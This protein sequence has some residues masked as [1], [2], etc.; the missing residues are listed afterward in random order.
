MNE[1]DRLARRDFLKASAATLGA[2]IPSGLFAAPV[3]K[4][5]RPLRL[6]ILGGTGFIGP[7]MAEYAIARGHQ[8]TLF[9]RGRREKFVGS[10]DRTEK[11]YGNRDPKLHA[12]SKVV[13]G[14]EIDDETSPK[15]LVELEGKKWDAVIDNSGYVPRIVKASAELLAPNV[16]QY[17][18]ISTL[19]VYADNS[20]PGLDESDTIAKIDDP[21]NEEIQ[22]HYGALKALCEQAAEKAMPKRVT[23]LRPGYI[24][25][26]KDL[27]DRF[28][29]W[30]I[31]TTRGGEVLVPGTPED[32][33]QFI[34]V[35]DLVE[36]AVHCVEHRTMGTFNVTGPEKKL[37]VGKLMEACQ[38]ASKANGDKGDAK[39]TYVPYDWLAM[40]GAPLG[41]LPILLPPTGD[42]AGFHQRSVAAAVK[43]GL[44]YR[45]P[46][47]TC[48]ALIKWWPEAV[49]LRE[50]VAKEVNEDRKAKNLPAA[51]QP[52]ADQLRAG[53]TPSAESKLLSLW[54]AKEKGN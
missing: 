15:G 9:N 53:L 39:F 33:V 13:D 31:R 48:S 46:E 29:Y 14:K 51:K 16:G 45:T 11:L 38:S 27:T 10:P 1:P 18:F 32:P 36:F 44:K 34:D 35:R 2:L 40:N 43:A 42:T 41:S 4:S 52:P 22:K 6:L 23:I 24:V 7:W 26:P 37:W 12:H 50:K 28:T 49:K 21:A 54:H 47:E 19:S 17:L 3:A 20:K 5:A 25:G 8:V 30:P